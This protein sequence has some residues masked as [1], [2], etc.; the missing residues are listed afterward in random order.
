MKVARPAVAVTVV[1]PE[2]TVLAA[3]FEATT[4]LE[5]SGPEVTMF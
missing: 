3:A 2:S 1:V 5:E 4:D